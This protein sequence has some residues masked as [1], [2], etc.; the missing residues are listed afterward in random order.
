[1]Q[2]AKQEVAQMLQHLPDDTSIEDIQYHLYVLEKVKKGQEDIANGR[3][4]T[5]EQAR[6]RLK[7]WLTP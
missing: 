7:K 2:T 6:E 5:H 4:Y 3:R 1:M